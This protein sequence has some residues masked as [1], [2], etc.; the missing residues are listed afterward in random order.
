MNE[1]TA[2]ISIVISGSNVMGD[3]LCTMEGILCPK[4]KRTKRFSYQGPVTSAKSL[5]D[6]IQDIFKDPAPADRE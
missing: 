2:I 5:V 6:V 3:A 1:D 4:G